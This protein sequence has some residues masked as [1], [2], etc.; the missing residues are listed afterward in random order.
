MHVKW[1]SSTW[2]DDIIDAAAKQKGEELDDQ[3]EICS[4]MRE[5][6]NSSQRQAIITHRLSE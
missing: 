3:I 1:A 2:Q 5:I 6:L 4:A